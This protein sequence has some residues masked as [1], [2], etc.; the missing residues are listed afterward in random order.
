MSWQYLT[1]GEIGPLNKKNLANYD[2][3]MQACLKTGAYCMIDIHNFARWN[4]DI[5]GQGGPTNAQFADL[6]TQLATK[7][8]NDSFVMFELMNEPHDL[9]VGDWADSCTAAVAA[10]RKAEAVPHIILLPGLNFSSA[11]T[12]ISSGWGAA[13]AKVTNPDKTTDNLI[14]DLHKYLDIDNSGNHVECVM[15]NVADTFVPVAAWLRKNK[16]QAIVSETGASSDPSVSTTVPVRTSLLSLLVLRGFLCPEH[17]HQ[18]Q[19]RCLSWIHCLDGRQRHLGLYPEP[20]THEERVRLDR[21]EVGCF[22]RD[23]RL[24]QRCTRHRIEYLG[25][26]SPS[27]NSSNIVYNIQDF[28]HQINQYLN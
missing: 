2:L 7:Y 11:G 10:I 19:L 15:D 18:R 5:I 20:R 4:G 13:M 24:G 25:L 21:P 14:F 22:V 16:R 26:D 6:W 23:R 1:N 27:R 8:A 9:V 28:H 17:R 3:L 12:F